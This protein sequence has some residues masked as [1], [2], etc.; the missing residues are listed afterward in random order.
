MGETTLCRE[1]LIKYCTGVGLDIGFGG[2]S[3][4]AGAITLD[5]GDFRARWPYQNIL[6]DARNLKWFKD[7]SLDYVYSSHCLEDFEDTALIL[8]EWFRVIKHGGFLV[9]FG[10]DQ[11]VYEESCTQRKVQ[12]NLGHKIKDFGLNY[13]KGI[14]EE[15][16]KDQYRIVHEIPLINGYSFDL[17]A[18]KL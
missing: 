6:G 10:P 9:L 5:L 2:D 11:K 3:I 18:E 15:H 17:V 14:L 13:I 7:F 1:R 8:K 16:F 4:A 12:P